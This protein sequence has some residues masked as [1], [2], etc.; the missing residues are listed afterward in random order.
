VSGLTVTRQGVQPVSTA[1]A[2]GWSILEFFGA[3]V[4]NT[5]PESKP[6]ACTR[7]LRH[8]ITIWRWFSEIGDLHR[9]NITATARAC[10]CREIALPYCVMINVVQC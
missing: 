8:R 2:I 1:P 5:T 6:R 7:R 10:D 3:V 4:I 9:L